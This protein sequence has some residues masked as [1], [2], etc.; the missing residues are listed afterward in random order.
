MFCF[1]KHAENVLIYVKKLEP[2]CLFIDKPKWLCLVWF[3]AK[4]PAYLQKINI[5]P[6]NAGHEV[7]LSSH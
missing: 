5:I 3:E 2:K 7:Q 1:Y 6:Y 4:H